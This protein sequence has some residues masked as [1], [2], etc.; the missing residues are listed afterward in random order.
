[1]RLY[2][3]NS[4][5]TQEEL[6]EKAGVSPPFLGAIERGE[7]PSPETLAGIA[8]GLKVNPYDL[9]K[10]EHNI[11][12]DINKL[13]EKMLKDIQKTVNQTIRTINVSLHGYSE[14][15]K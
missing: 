10:P 7:W 6:A 4:G 1:M 11:S 13:T 5:L 14:P 3:K 2:R 15:E 8:A 9:L 12:R